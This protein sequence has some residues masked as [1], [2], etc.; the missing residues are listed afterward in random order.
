LVEEV[1][2]SVNCSLV[3]FGCLVYHLVWD[4]PI[5]IFYV[6]FSFLTVDCLRYLVNQGG[7]SYVLL[8]IYAG[9]ELSVV[10]CRKR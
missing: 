4:I 1:K 7:V 2:F 6:F 10:C 9:V 8:S 5:D 3:S